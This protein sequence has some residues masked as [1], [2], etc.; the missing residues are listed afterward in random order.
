M[1]R[2]GIVVMLWVTTRRYPTLRRLV[3]KWTTIRR[4]NITIYNQS[5]RRTQ[6]P[7]P[8]GWKWRVAK[9]SGDA[10]QLERYYTRHAMD[11]VAYPLK[12]S[13]AYNK[14]HAPRLHSHRDYG[15]LYFTT[16]LAGYP[17]T[18]LLETIQ[19]WMSSLSPKCIRILKVLKRSIHY[20]QQQPTTI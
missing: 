17:Q 9:G 19:A 13:L 20:N 8:A 6:P 11:S 12:G 18:K 4:Y 3:L 2:F 5:F 16:S 14:R 1:W 7:T 10:P 15:T